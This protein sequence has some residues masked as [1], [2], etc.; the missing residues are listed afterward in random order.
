MS[1]L[2]VDNISSKTGTAQAIEID[3]SGR[4]LMP[5]KPA[6]HAYRNAGHVAATATIVWNEAELNQG[7]HFNTSTGLFIAPVAGIYHFSA[8]G[9]K[10]NSADGNF[11]LRFIKGGAA[12][13]GTW[14]FQDD[15][16][17]A[18]MANH[19]SGVY[20]MSANETMG[21]EITHGSLYAI[22]NRHNTFSGFLVG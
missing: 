15:G 5:V 17:S 10:V 8:F 3:S 16:A 12:V 14:M 22:S 2:F 6:F 1:T 11:G 4:V 18:F 7:N 19:I 9:M 13:T 20:S 21:V